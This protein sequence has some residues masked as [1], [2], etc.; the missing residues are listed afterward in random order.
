[1][2]R[3]WSRA[4]SAFRSFRDEAGDHVRR[5]VEGESGAVTPPRLF[6]GFDDV[7]RVVGEAAESVRPKDLKRVP[8]GLVKV[9]GG[10]SWTREMKRLSGASRSDLFWNPRTHEI[11]RYS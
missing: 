7:A 8:D 2:S 6:L 9:M 11:L 1:M 4:K 3:A 10:E 5:V